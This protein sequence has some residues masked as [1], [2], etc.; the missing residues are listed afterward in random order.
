MS[1]AA[2]A[3]GEPLLLRGSPYARGRAQAALC[4]GQADFVRDAIRARL[5][6]T[7][8]AL[9]RADVRA[10]IDGIHAFTLAS[11]PE[12][13]EEIR[14]IADGFGI[15]AWSIFTYL[16]AS[17]AMDL[18]AAAERGQEDGCTSFAATKPGE[19]AIL[20]KNRDY[21]PEHIPIQRVFLHQDPAWGGRGILCVGSLGSPGNFSSGINSDGLAVSDTATRT[22]RHAAGMHRYFLLT[23][24]LVHCRTVAEALAGIRGMPHV[25]GGTL[26]L[27]DASG[28]VA[29]VELGT[30]SVGIDQGSLGRVG[31]SNHFV[32]PETASLNLDPPAGPAARNSAARLAALLGRLRSLP[33]RTGVAD[34]IALMR[35]H[36]D[37]GFCRHGGPDIG[38][39]ISSAIYDCRARAL[40]FAAGNPCSARFLRYAAAGDAPIPPAAQ[41]GSPA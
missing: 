3:P 32:R 10:L 21:R 13:L 37:G 40:I 29:A 22:R 6:E 12:V 30:D 39:T 2:C 38:H 7:A 17:H 14:G 15:D 5:A 24:L 41:E 28:A 18:L 36:G 9:E 19:G 26:V 34:A 23:W 16:N 25:G 11:F 20:A 31:R 35:S 8:P 33:A 4:P 27:A 1:A